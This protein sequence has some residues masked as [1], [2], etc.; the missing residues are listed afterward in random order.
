MILS[1]R[2]KILFFIGIFLTGLIGIFSGYMRTNYSK[3][4]SLI[5]PNVRADVAACGW[6]GCP[7]TNLQCDNHQMFG[8]GDGC[9]GGDGP[10]AACACGTGGDSDSGGG[11]GG[12]G[13]CSCAGDSP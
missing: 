12:G 9:C 1:A 8:D 6:C 4:G 11:G 2:K 3:S 5:I 13:A 7:Y 10:S